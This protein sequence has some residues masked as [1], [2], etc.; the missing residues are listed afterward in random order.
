MLATWSLRVL[1]IAAGTWLVLG[2]AYVARPSH[3]LLPSPLNVLLFVVLASLTTGALGCLLTA[4][5]LDHLTG[6]SVKL[7]ARD[8]RLYFELARVRGEL[9]QLRE[10]IEQTMDLSR[11]ALALVGSAAYDD[12]YADGLAR[13]PARDA[14]VLP[15]ERH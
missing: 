7:E 4:R 6:H 5:I 13:L 10:V 15:I 3:P 1:I 9:A 2:T 12:G 11:P 14:K 8:G